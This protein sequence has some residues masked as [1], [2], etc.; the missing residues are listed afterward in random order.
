MLVNLH[1]YEAEAKK[2][3]APEYF[4]FFYGGACDEVTMQLNQQAYNN[5]SLRPKMCSGNEE[6]KLGIKLFGIDNKT[7]ILVAPTAY[8]GLIN[9]AAETEAARAAMKFD[10]IM[11]A[12]TMSN[13]SL[14]E[15]ADTGN[16]KLWFQ[17]FLF[18]KR[19]ITEVLIKR[20]E[21]NGYKA[22]V[23]SVDTQILGI[24]ERDRRNRFS[25]PSKYK[26]GNLVEF[27]NELEN[28]DLAIKSDSNNLFDKNLS[29]KDVEWVCS[30]TKLPVL[31]KGILNSEDISPALNSGVQGLIVSNHG[32]RQL[33]TA[34][35][36]LLVL[37]SII[38]EVAG[39]VPVLVDGG[40]R[41]GTSVLKAIL[42]GADAVLVGRPIVW[43][44]TVDGS[45][46]VF[47]ILSILHNE[48]DTAVGMCGLHSINEARG[49][50]RE[51]LYQE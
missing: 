31:L 28:S 23:L 48:L 40:I 38:N 44:L 25:I 37:P 34:V 7:P 17:T 49:A 41:R 11:V 2:I 36:S 15:I 32:G 50:D 30:L 27:Q 22:I 1:D 9:S 24:R 3:L 19:K 6:R 20:A 18:N 39:R 13:C 14:K 16:N 33:D 29:W 43:G 35:P 5:I 8:H 10:T 4:D 42:L 45:D 51:Y 46:G 21:E 26:L 47:K 12:A